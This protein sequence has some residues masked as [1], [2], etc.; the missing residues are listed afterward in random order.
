M[1]TPIATIGQLP[2]SPSD[3]LNDNFTW[4][5]I[6]VELGK[7]LSARNFMD[8]D[9]NIS[10]IEGKLKDLE[11]KIIRFKILLTLNPPCENNL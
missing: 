5:E 4:V 8:F 6:F 9:G 3:R 7:L 2:T 1:E 11:N 10:E